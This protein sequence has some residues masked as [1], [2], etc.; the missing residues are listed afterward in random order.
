MTTGDITRCV[1]DIQELG[2]WEIDCIVGKQGGSG[3]ALLVLSERKSRREIIR[4]FIPKGMDIGKISKAA[5]SR[6]ERWMNN[7]PRK[8]LGYKTANEMAA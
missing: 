2:H 6:I 1:E 7:Y 3:A 4:R 5:I 8:I